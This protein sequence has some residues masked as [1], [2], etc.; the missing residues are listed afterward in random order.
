MK[1]KADEVFFTAIV[2][3]HAFRTMQD[4]QNKFRSVCTI[5]TD[6]CILRIE[7]NPLILLRRVV[8][9]Y[10]VYSLSLEC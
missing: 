3:E 2:Q 7:K 10:Y 8:L 6:I 9:Q 1:T 5:D 4:L